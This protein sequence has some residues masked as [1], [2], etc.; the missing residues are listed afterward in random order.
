MAYAADD[1]E[2]QYSA[3][4]M[5]GNVEPGLAGLRSPDIQDEDTRLY[6]AYGYWCLD[7]SDAAAACLRA[8]KSNRSKAIA[9][10]LA[11]WIE[12]DDFEAV[13]FYDANSSRGVPTADLPGF[14]VTALKRGQ[15]DAQQSVADIVGRPIEPDLVISFNVYGPDLPQSVYDLDCPVAI[16]ATD[17]D[18]DL[19]TSYQDMQRCDVIVGGMAYEQFVLQ[20][21]F[22]G[23]V[24]AF[25]GFNYYESEPLPP[26]LAARDVDVL[27]TGK[28]FAPHWQDRAQFLFRL[29]TIDD[30]SLKIRIYQGYLPYGEYVAAMA[31]AK[32]MAIT[33]RFPFSIHMTRVADTVRHRIAVLKYGGIDTGAYFEADCDPFLEVGE[34][35]LEEDVL[36]HLRNFESH[37]RRLADN[38]QNT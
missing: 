19:I 33:N 30:P 16:L 37:R 23:R 22:G 32:L 35:T 21:I 10:Q 15:F 5:C 29:A 34:A 13:I 28:A 3:L 24:A 7:Q 27:F 18:Q 11:G 17:F 36:Q 20:R 6:Q 25:P 31:G 26:S 4:I 8:V 9:D 38:P 2:V 12:R 14:R 1:R